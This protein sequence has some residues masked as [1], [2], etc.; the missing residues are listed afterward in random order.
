MLEISSNKE[1]ILNFEVQ[2]FSVDP[3]Q[4]EGKLRMI[5]DGIEYGFS[6]EIK[7][8]SIYVEIPPLKK[9]VKR[10]I[11]EGEK[12]EAKLEV[13]TGDSYLSPW[14][15]TFTVKNPVLLEAKLV[16]KSGISKMNVSLKKESKE[17]KPKFKSIKNIKEQKQVP[18]MRK[19]DITEEMVYNY[20]AS[21]GTKSRP[22]QE[23]LY[24]Q[25]VRTIGSSEPYEVLKSLVKFYKNKDL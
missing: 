11:K 13:V 8:E 9:V 2:S 16:E 6:A 22:V 23:V 21:K 7:P 4:L 24:N 10:E 1:R 25:T 14:A 5:I 18:K 19:E 3:T 20:I 17:E 15:G 12:I